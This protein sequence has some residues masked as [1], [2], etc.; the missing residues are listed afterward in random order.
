MADKEINGVTY[1]CRKLPADPGLYLFLRVLKVFEPAHTVFISVVSGQSDEILIE[2]FFTFV[3]GMD[4]AAVHKILL[5]CV[6]HCQVDGLQAV[7]GVN[8]ETM[9]E[10]IKVAAWF[11]EV[12]Y[13][14]FL[15]ESPLGAFFMPTQTGT[16]DSPSTRSEESPQTSQTTTSSSDQPQ[17]TQ[18][19]R[20]AHSTIYAPS[21]P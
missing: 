10:L 13:R 1:T 19:Q 5:E 9:H 2:D 18:S 21:I 11:L 16:S 14:D 6:G 20:S 15:A 3:R 17:G 7:P 12:Q 8:P 4:P